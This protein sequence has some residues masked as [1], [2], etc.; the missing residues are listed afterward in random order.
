ML[1]FLIMYLL[2]TVQL[3][4]VSCI[5]FEFTPSVGSTDLMRSMVVCHL[6]LTGAYA[7]VGASREDGC[8]S[9]AEQ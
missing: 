3:T 2:C 1:V 5:E 7:R 8:R 4:S 9:S 6:M